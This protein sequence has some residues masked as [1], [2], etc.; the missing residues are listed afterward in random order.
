[1]DKIH[2]SCAFSFISKI[3]QRWHN[4]E[5]NKLAEIRPKKGQLSK[6]LAKEFAMWLALFFPFSCPLHFVLSVILGT[7][8]LEL[9]TLTAGDL[10]T[11]NNAQAP[12]CHCPDDKELKQPTQVL[13]ILAKEECRCKCAAS[14]FLHLTPAFS[15]AWRRSAIPGD[16][17]FFRRVKPKEK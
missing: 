16:G 10:G 6:C 17:S 3:L 15:E 14:S 8:W 12:S 11:E 5:I 7:T 13:Y 4:V 2:R 1:M 9:Y